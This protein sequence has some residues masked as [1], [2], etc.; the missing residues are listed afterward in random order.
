MGHRVSISTSVKRRWHLFASKFGHFSSDNVSS[1]SEIVSLVPNA[2]RIASQG[3]IHFW[4][5]FIFL[6]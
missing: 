3:V 1:V 5:R 6:Q 4:L 2:N